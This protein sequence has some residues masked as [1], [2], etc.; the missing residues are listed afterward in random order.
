MYAHLSLTVVLVLGH[1]MVTLSRKTLFAIHVT[2]LVIG[3]LVVL[4]LLVWVLSLTKD[5][6]GESITIYKVRLA[7]AEFQWSKPESL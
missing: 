7:D 2:L 5:R 6:F 3:P 4:G 1:S